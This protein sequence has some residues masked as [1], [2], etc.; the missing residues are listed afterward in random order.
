MT[1]S[2]RD[3]TATMASDVAEQGS[4]DTPKLEDRK[5]WT[6]PELPWCLAVEDDYITTLQFWHGP[7]ASRP[8]LSPIVLHPYSVHS[9]SWRFVRLTVWFGSITSQGTVP[10]AQ[11]SAETQTRLR[12]FLDD[13]DLEIDGSD[14]IGS[15]E[16]Q[17]RRAQ[18]AGASITAVDQL[19]PG[20]VGGAPA[21][22]QADNDQAIDLLGV[23]GQFAN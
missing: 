21:Q 11:A 18:R 10:H 12:E 2:P 17:Q 15:V 4:A 3:G 7:Q 1:K 22:E 13:I 20:G 5:V 23:G 19:L 8:T 14:A 16:R 6:C 9:I